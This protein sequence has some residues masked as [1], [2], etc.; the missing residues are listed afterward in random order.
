ME[1]LGPK[2]SYQGLY[3]GR[4]Q[5][6]VFEFDHIAFGECWVWGNA[7]YYT[8]EPDWQGVFVAT[9]REAL[10]LGAKRIIHRGDWLTRVRALI[11]GEG[12]GPAEE[13][14]VEGEYREV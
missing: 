11:A 12:E 10:R 14:T 5:Y 2:A 13:G 7:L 1:A 9:K 4:R 3:M 6:R 8:R